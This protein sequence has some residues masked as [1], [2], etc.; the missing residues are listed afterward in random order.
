MGPAGRLS[1]VVCGS[2]ESPRSAWRWTWASGPRSSRRTSISMQVP[3]PRYGTQKLQT[4]SKIMFVVMPLPPTLVP[5]FPNRADRIMEPGRPQTI[6][7]TTCP[8]SSR[9]VGLDVVPP[10]SQVQCGRKVRTARQQ[11]GG[12]LGAGHQ[13]ARERGIRLLLGERIGISH[14]MHYCSALRSSS[15]SRAFSTAAAPCGVRARHAGGDGGRARDARG[16]RASPWVVL[17]AAVEQG[18]S[19]ARRSGLLL[20]LFSRPVAGRR[21]RLAP[22]LRP[23]LRA[24]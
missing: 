9:V 5:A 7:S 14:L 17:A 11:R 1:D 15:F 3:P 20:L 18:R 23:P 6:Q 19:R 2:A 24:E 12:A 4:S 22:S 13:R 21:P 16:A 8:N 10:R